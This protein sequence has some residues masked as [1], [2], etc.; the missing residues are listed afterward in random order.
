MSSSAPL[1]TPNRFKYNGKEFDSD[2]NLGWY[3]YGARTY[4]A[5][6]ARFNQ[7][8]PAADIYLDF[9]PYHYVLNNPIKHIDPTGMLTELFDENGN[10][11]GEDEKGN[12]GNVSI[13]TDKDEVDRIKQNTEDGKLATKED[14]ASGVQTTKQALKEAD[15]VI[16]RTLKNG[17]LKEES[18][19]VAKG[20]VIRNKTGELPTVGKDGQASAE[21]E[22]PPLPGLTRDQDVEALIHSHPIGLFQKDGKVFPFS[23]N[24]PT[25]PDE[26]AFKRFKSNIIVGRLGTLTEVRADANG[27]PIDP[28]PVGAVIY[29]GGKSASIK[30]KR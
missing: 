9:T 14:V 13:I 19:I 7:I 22:T 20:V 16:K 23:A 11:I 26:A 25:G 17:G 8:D 28:R 18:S 1:S 29:Q 24:E 4:D 27:N 15:A 12:D 2:F 30:K 10:K 6:I 5:Q 3:D 21:T